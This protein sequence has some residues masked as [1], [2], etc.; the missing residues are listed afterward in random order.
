[1]YRLST[2]ECLYFMSGIV[3]I[4]F[5]EAAGLK[6]VNLGGKSDPYVRVSE[7]NEKAGHIPEHCQTSSIDCTVDPK[8]EETMV[9]LVNNDA[10]TCRVNVFDKGLGKMLLA[11]R[12]FLIKS[13]Y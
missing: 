2:Y 5:H 13:N 9:F 1:M 4:T 10:K 7:F 3:M 6:A 11:I 8:W 12:T